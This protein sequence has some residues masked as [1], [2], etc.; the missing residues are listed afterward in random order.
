[1]MSDK[2]E[3][4]ALKYWDSYRFFL[5]VVENKSLSAAARQ[6]GVTQPT[7]G[8]HIRE[9]ERHLNTRLFDRMNF[10][11]LV[12]P[13]GEAILDL[14]ESLKSTVQAIERR[15]GGQ[16]SRLCGPVCMSTSEGLGVCWL[17]P[18]LSEFKA[19]Y[20][21]IELEVTVSSNALSIME[22][23]CDI[24]LWLGNPEC[25]DL[26][27][28][29]VGTVRFGLFAS[30]NYIETHGQPLVRQDLAVHPVIS[31]G[32]E[33]AESFAARFIRSQ[34]PTITGD[35]FVSNSLMAQIAAAQ[36]G[37]GLVVLPICIVQPTFGLHRVLAQ[38]FAPTESL[39]LLTH[40]DL[41]KTARIR[42]VLS[43]VAKSLHKDA[44]LLLG[45]AEEPGGK[46]ELEA[47][48]HPVP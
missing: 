13:A 11:Y 24:A 26:V 7:V 2:I 34:L 20:P 3:T 9:L 5:A 15:I 16:D 42:A 1:M 21:E 23:E 32:G 14:A 12:T 41:T 10:G 33:A 36:A 22:R 8:R 48:H 17:I 29:R 19:R 27:G 43:Y 25:E 46:D 47:A 45:E 38:D 18:R 4:D 28:R 6:L 39:W 37:L 30:P 40:R 35:G 44:A 31:W